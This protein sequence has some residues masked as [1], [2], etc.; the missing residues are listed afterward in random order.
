MATPTAP[1]GRPSTLRRLI[2][3]LSVGSV[4][5]YGLGKLAR[6]LAPGDDW[7]VIALRLVVLVIGGFIARKMFGGS[8]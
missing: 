4:I 3:F 5:V 6:M 1:E 2:I 7:L 8:E